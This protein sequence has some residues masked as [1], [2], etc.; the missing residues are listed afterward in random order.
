LNCNREQNERQARLKE[1]AEAKRAEELTFKPAITRSR[2][3]SRL[4]TGQSASASSTGDE[5]DTNSVRD[6]AARLHQYEERRQAR[7]VE[8]REAAKAQEKKEATFK[9][10]ILPARRSATPSG[11]QPQQDQ[12]EQEQQKSGSVFDRLNALAMERAAAAA[13]AASAEEAAR[14]VIHVRSLL[15][16]LL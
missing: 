4:S 12:Q 3:T 1:E 13:S 2:S 5:P 10:A 6:I 9:P 15:L 11:R 8:A 7:L 14:K 16:L